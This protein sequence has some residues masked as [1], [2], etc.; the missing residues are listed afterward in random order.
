MRYI[1]IPLCVVSLLLSGCNKKSE[2]IEKQE[3]K[4]TF[5]QQG[6]AF[7]E[8]QDY[9]NAEISFKQAIEDNP[10]LP[11]PYFSLATIY[12]QYKPNPFNAIFYYSHFIEMSSDSEKTEI[13]KKQI[14]QVK[15]G[16]AK[17]V[18]E[19]SG[20]NKIANDLNREKAKNK[21]LY[22]M[23]V[24]LEKEVKAAKEAQTKAPV[25]GAVASSEASRTTGSPTATSSGKNQIYTVVAGDTLSK[26]S[27]KYYGNSSQWDIIY[28][29]NRDRMK[30]ASDLRVGQTLVIPQK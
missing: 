1:F 4:S 5:I 27:K 7:M 6:K 30:S 22:K 17:Q 19:R 28:D 15:V 11:S 3:E 8:N 21:E 13:A 16:I 26:I 20:A 18:L 24:A 23:V 2:S 10:L 9:D 12:Q 29:A 14:K 25:E